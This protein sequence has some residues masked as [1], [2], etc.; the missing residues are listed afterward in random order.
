M[1]VNKKK[2]KGNIGIQKK[3]QAYQTFEG[4]QIISLKNFFWKVILKQLS[5]NK[6]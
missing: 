3:L 6:R 4:K 1:S 2:V 5:K